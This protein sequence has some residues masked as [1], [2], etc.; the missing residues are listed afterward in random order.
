MD[1]GCVGT[2]VVFVAYI[3]QMYRESGIFSYTVAKQVV[4]LLQSLVSR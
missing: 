4:S 3:L 2:E 1:K